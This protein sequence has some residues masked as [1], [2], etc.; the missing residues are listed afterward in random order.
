MHKSLNHTRLSQSPIEIYSG[1]LWSQRQMWRDV[2]HLLPANACL[3][4]ID[5]KNERQTQVMRRIAQS[6]RDSGRQVLIWITPKSDAS[7]R[8]RAE[9]ENIITR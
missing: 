2:S 7:D 3:L 5:T 4:V 8:S 1:A 9:T 6:F